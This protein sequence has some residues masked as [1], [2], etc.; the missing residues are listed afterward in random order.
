MPFLRPSSRCVTATRERRAR[1]PR[2][3]GL[4]AYVRACRGP[5]LLLLSR[6]TAFSSLPSYT[7]V[8]SLGTTSAPPSVPL[9]LAALLV[10]ETALDVAL[11]D[12]RST[13]G[14]ALFH[15]AAL[16]WL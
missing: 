14:I 3:Q 11:A 13:V 12:T 6:H 15:V 10:L 1:S 9:S 5:Q 7:A 2:E 16:R 8:G 4:T